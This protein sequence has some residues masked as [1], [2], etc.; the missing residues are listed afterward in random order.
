MYSKLR[1]FHRALTL[2]DTN[3]ASYLLPGPTRGCIDLANA[4]H[5]ARGLR[6]VHEER[7]VGN[8]FT[9]L[10]SSFKQGFIEGRTGKIAKEVA[11]LSDDQAATLTKI[12]AADPKTLEALSVRDEAVAKMSGIVKKANA[13]DG[14]GLTDDE[15]AKFAKAFAAVQKG[16][17]MTDDQVTKLAKTF[18]DAKKVKEAAKVSDEEVAKVSDM[19]RKANTGAK[20]AAKY[21]D[22][23]LA[24]LSKAFAAAQ[25][26]AALSDDQVVNLAKL[27]ASAKPITSTSDGRIGKISK[28]L[29][30]V[31]KKDKKAWSTLK[32]TIVAILGVT[33]GGAIIYWVYNQTRKGS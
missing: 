30:G 18:V 6:R 12:M 4:D 15:V 32:K 14:V 8:G 23:E 10:F 16:A 2:D 1:S 24:T 27:L 5:E 22:D 25:K 7:G 29:A 9:S 3:D 28:A 31:A 26:E 13:G 17:G 33:V 21:T 19:F 20:D 11:K